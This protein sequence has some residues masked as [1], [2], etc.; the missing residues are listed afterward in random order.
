M[1]GGVRA[2]SRG[3][4]ATRALLRQLFQIQVEFTRL[5]NPEFRVGSNGICT[6]RCPLTMAHDSTEDEAM[7]WALEVRDTS[8]KGRGV[9]A[10]RDFAAGELVEL[11]PVLVGKRGS[12]EAFKDYEFSWSEAKGRGQVDL[13][14]AAIALGYGSLY[15]G[16][17]P[18][19][20]RYEVDRAAQAIRFVAARVIA[21]GEELTINYSAESGDAVSTS[22]RWFTKRPHLK[23]MP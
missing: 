16:A 6:M 21:K 15:N 1:S 5:A 2:R 20:L 9:F 17:N 23:R 22:D 7:N 19:N 8:G 10:L 3:R 18:A 14:R 4:A 12:S 11:A 13:Y